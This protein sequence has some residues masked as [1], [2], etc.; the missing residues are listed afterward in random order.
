MIDN[1][2]MVAASLVSEGVYFIRKSSH[3]GQTLEEDR[4][5]GLIC[6]RIGV[7]T[8]RKEMGDRGA[9]IFRG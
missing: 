3:N 5:P 8:G 1:L 4:G 6:R 7:G 9:F 2:G